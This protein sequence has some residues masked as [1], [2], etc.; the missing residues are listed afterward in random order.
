LDS[1][2]TGTVVTISIGG[3]VYPKLFGDLPF[4][5]EWLDTGTIVNYAYA[6]PT[7]SSSTV[8]KQFVYTGSTGPA[9]PITVTQ[10][11]IVAGNY[12]TQYFLTVSSPYGTAGGQSWYDSGAT[13]YAVLDTG[14]VDHG[15][16]TRRVFTGWSGDASGTDYAQSN[17]VTMDAP[18][19]GIAVWKTQHAVAFAV[20]PPSAGTTN[21]SGTD[22]WYDTGTAGIP[23]SAASDPLNSAF[24]SW[25][26]STP[27]IVIDNVNAQSTTITVNGPGN[28]TATFTRIEYSLLA[29]WNPLGSGNVSMNNTEPY[30][31]GDVVELTAN[32]IA[33][34]GF[35][36]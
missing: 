10:A 23:V 4:T 17:A 30:Y 28:V 21:P 35:S 34:W 14:V 18:K 3:N 19:N 36:Q 26:S 8:D 5:T 33:G 31:Y 2:T 25:N 6:A 7:V 15:N 11:E 16:G 22:N 27:D 24:V 32:P 9:S 29:E 13:A 20:D 12:G 1:T